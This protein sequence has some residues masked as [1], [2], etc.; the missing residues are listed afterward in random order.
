MS[1]AKINK[2]KLMLKRT[3]PK[4][5]DRKIWQRHLESIKQEIRML[6]NNPQETLPTSSKEYGKTFW[7]VAEKENM[8]TSMGTAWGVSKTGEP[9]NRVTDWSSGNLPLRPYPDRK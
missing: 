9:V 1:S 4:G 7:N 8:R 2:L 5:T 6:E 3:R